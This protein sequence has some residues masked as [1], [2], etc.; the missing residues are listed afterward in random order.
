VLSWIHY[1]TTPAQVQQLS[2]QKAGMNSPIIFKRPLLPDG[3]R[4]RRP[5]NNIALTTF[6][7]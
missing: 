6:L 1:A 5:K 2:G 7:G 3:R 4:R